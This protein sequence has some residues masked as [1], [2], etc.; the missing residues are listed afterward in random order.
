[1]RTQVNVETIV[2]E[3]L[4]TCTL[5]TYLFIDRDITNNKMIHSDQM[6]P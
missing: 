6:K 5:L 2:S 1:M 4:H 3:R